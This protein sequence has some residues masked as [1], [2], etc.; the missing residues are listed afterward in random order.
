VRTTAPVEPFTEVTAAL[1]VPPPVTTKPEPTI[2]PPIVEVV[3][4]GIAVE[5][6]TE[7]HVDHVFDD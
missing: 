3:A 1:R 7:I 2:T 5:V 6:D 4:G